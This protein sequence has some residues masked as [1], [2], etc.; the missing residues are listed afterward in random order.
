MDKI[1]V[2]AA[3]AWAGIVEWIAD[4]LRTVRKI[5]NMPS[6]RAE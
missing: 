5:M 1:G 4:K 6:R 3:A 2:F